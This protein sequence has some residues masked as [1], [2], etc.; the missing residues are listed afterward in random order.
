MALVAPAAAARPPNPGAGAR[1]TIASVAIG[2]NEQTGLFDTLLAYV[3]DCDLVGVLS[4]TTQ[5]TVFAPTD[6][7]FAAAG[8]GPDSFGGACPA[9]LADV[10]LYHVAPGRWSSDRLA[11]N[12]GGT[13]SM[14]N[15]DTTSI[16]LTSGG[17]SIN[18]STVIV[19]DVTSSNGFIH[20]IDEV[21]FPGG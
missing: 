19:A 20:A 16:T 7:A 2:I 14:A 8:L 17:L 10:L 18:S 6:A 11:D 5:L 4:G 1:P 12:A 13:L 21:L 9:I 15:G 3:A